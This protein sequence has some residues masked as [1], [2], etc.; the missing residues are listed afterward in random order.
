MDA[1]VASSIS[2]Y[3]YCLIKTKGPLNLS[4]IQMT[5]RSYDSLIRSQ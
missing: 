4:V 3:L 5:K 2:R 1:S